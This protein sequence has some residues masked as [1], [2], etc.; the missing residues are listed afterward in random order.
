MGAGA[1]C[2]GNSPELESSTRN[3][4]P[5]HFATLVFRGLS[6]ELEAGFCNEEQSRDSSYPVK[7]TCPRVHFLAPLALDVMEEV[8]QFPVAH[9][10]LMK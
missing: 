6:L 5:V 10:L 7:R 8:D 3:C 1:L 9:M 4:L 2:E